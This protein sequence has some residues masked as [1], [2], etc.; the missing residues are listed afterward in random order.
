LFDEP[1]EPSGIARGLAGGLDRA[2]GEF[3]ALGLKAFLAGNFQKGSAAELSNK[4]AKRRVV[5]RRLVKFQNV[6]LC[7]IR[8]AK[9]HE[10]ARG[11]DELRGRLGVAL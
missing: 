1:R 8:L 4:F 9:V 6:S 3:P 10:H 7:Q 11:A 2:V 5:K